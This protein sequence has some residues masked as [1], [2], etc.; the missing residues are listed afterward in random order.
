MGEHVY[1]FRVYPWPSYAH[2]HLPA[3]QSYHDP[4]I[5][6]CPADKELLPKA[7]SPPQ[8]S[9]D[10]KKFPSM[11][12]L[13]CVSLLCVQYI[14]YFPPPFFYDIQTSQN[15]K[16]NVP[17]CVISRHLSI[18]EWI[19]CKHVFSTIWVQS[20]LGPEVTLPL[21]FVLIELHRGPSPSYTLCAMP[22]LA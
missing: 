12:Q 20:S 13:P 5:V 6:P 3:S 17:K 15:H 22:P 8:P 4:L 2:S 10:R 11:R 21:S 19:L 7:A 1:T 16:I 14:I 9:H 18:A